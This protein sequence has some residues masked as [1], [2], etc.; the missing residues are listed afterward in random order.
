MSRFVE[1]RHSAGLG[2]GEQVRRARVPRDEPGVEQ[3]RRQQERDGRGEER[4][5]DGGLPV[6]DAE[7]DGGEEG[8][9]GGED[10]E[11]GAQEGLPV[12]A[13]GE[14]GGRRRS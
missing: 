12:G 11:E 14:S 9:R 2:G 5:D 8:G 1:A 7:P 3:R 10:Q 6:R 4:R 13:W